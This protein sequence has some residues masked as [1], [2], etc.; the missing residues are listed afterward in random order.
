MVSGTA[1]T[2]KLSPV[3]PTA[4]ASSSTLTLNNNHHH[5]HQNYSQQNPSRLNGGT[6]SPNSADS[7]SNAPTSSQQS[8]LLST[9]ISNVRNMLAEGG[10]I[11]PSISLIPI[12]QV[13]HLIANQSNSTPRLSTIYYFAG[14]M[15]RRIQ[16]TRCGKASQ[17]QHNYH[18]TTGD[19]FIQ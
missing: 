18:R 13:N 15:Q 19:F 10:Q 4:A 6:T 11:T 1:T 16:S 14:T 5:H 2:T 17:Q 12:K 8:L 3:V 7:N 9:V